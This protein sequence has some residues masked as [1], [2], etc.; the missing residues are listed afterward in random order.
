MSLLLV[1]VNDIFTAL[2]KVIGYFT[3]KILQLS[4]LTGVPRFDSFSHKWLFYRMF[5]P[6]LFPQSWFN[7]TMPMSLI[8]SSTYAQVL[9]HS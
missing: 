7:F 3:V 5:Y 9:S 2:D 8:P 6:P 1:D 4:G